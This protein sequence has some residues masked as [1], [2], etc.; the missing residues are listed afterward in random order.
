MKLNNTKDIV[1]D[2]VEDINI[3]IEATTIEQISSF[4]Y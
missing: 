2:G 1:I 3:P 4:K